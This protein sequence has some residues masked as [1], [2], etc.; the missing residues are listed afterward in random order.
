[1]IFFFFFFHLLPDGCFGK[2]KKKA[3][4]HGGPWERPKGNG[5]KEGLCAGLNAHTPIH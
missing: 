5:I 2:G 1:M 4:D 3:S